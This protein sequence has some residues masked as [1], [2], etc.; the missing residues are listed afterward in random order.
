MKQSLRHALVLTVAAAAVFAV[1][2]NKQAP[3]ATDAAA[4]ATADTCPHA[5]AIPGARSGTAAATSG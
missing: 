5:T 4:P 1:G 3:P 2:C